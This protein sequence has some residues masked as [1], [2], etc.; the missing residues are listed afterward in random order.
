MDGGSS[1]R[2]ES[3]SG[4]TQQRSVERTQRTVE[5]RGDEDLEQVVDDGTGHVADNT[6]RPRNNEFRVPRRDAS[7]Q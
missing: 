6:Q 7:H 5:G 3:A 2:S 4:R 1:F